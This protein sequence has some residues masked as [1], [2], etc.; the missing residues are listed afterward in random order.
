MRRP[1][2]IELST[3]YNLIKECFNLQEKE[4]IEIDEKIYNSFRQAMNAYQREFT[5]VGKI[6][7]IQLT[8]RVRWLFRVNLED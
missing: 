3:Y 6:R 2:R 5:V 7:S 1:K 8:K 4:Y